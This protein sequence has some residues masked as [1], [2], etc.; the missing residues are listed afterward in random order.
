MHVHVHTVLTGGVPDVYADVVAIRRMLCR[1][2]AL[3]AV[4]KRLNFGFLLG[5]HVKIARDVPAW[6]YQNMATA[7]TVVII[8]DIRKG[9]F[10]QHVFGPAQLAL[11]SRHGINPFSV[12]V[13]TQPLPRNAPVY[14]VFRK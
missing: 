8:A 10:Q 6:D 9:A 11:V 12:C 13:D 5:G 4:K 2:H 1:Y 14:S 7:Q 3:R